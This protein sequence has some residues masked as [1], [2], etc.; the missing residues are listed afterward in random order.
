LTRY[1]RHTGN[2]RGLAMASKTLEQMR[3]GGVYDHVGFGFH[4]YSTD[5]EWLVPHFEKMLYDQAMLITAYT[6]AWL[7]V[8]DPVFERTVR[9]IAAYVVRDMTSPE[10]GFYS[11][12]D[13]D[14]Q[15]E[16]GLFYLWTTDELEDFL[17]AEDAA[18]AASVWNFESEGNYRDEVGGRRTGRNIPHLRRNH[19]S[20]AH[21]LEMTAQDFEKRLESIRLRLFEARQHRVHPLKD[22]KVLADWNG[23]MAAAMAFAGRVFDQP[24]WIETA[25]RAVG[26]VL[27]G[28]R[29]DDGRLLHRYRDGEASIP[30]F[31]DDHVFMTTAMLELYDATFDSSFLEG[32]MQ[33]QQRT[34]ELFWDPAGGA[35]FFTADDNEELLVRQ[36]EVYDGAIPSGNSMAADNLVRLE[37]LTGKTEYRQRA[38][39][40]FAAFSSQAKQ[41]PSAH[42]Q[43]MSA[44]QR[45]AAPSLEVVIAG[46][47]KAEDTMLL[48]ATVR[49]MYL[50]HAAVLLVPPDENGTA[51]RS[52]VPFTEGLE[53]VDGRAAAYVCRDFACQLPTTDPAR[54]S[55]LLEE[56]TLP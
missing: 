9:E 18:F 47:T 32:A 21:D 56:A 19:E 12:E 38:E 42:A 25:K 3:L 44:L 10:G 15:G 53:P 31:L 17:G 55:A 20:I 1:S 41:L 50:P 30:A 51:I 13:A 5:S 8:K 49:G 48:I 34:D 43:L 23:L 54:L 2:Q 33:T 40:L 46:E 29:N 28:M 37:R 16:E 35:Y 24:E 11:A 26:F 4:R 36:K 22:D 52:L 39:Q 45:S 27:E 14:S 7:A 6:E